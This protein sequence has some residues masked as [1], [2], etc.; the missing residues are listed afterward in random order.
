VATGNALQVGHGW[1]VFQGFQML[2]FSVG[3]RKCCKGVASALQA[4][5][6]RTNGGSICIA[7]A[8][9]LSNRITEHS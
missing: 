2:T 3:K 4:T 7:I 6:G 5:A 9:A 8:D 1:A